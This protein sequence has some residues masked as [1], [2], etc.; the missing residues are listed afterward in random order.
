MN[1][2]TEFVGL[3][4]NIVTKINEIKPINPNL[5]K[6]K[7]MDLFDLMM[8]IAESANMGWYFKQLQDECKSHREKVKIQN[9]SKG[10]M[11]D[12]L[13][14]NIPKSGELLIVNARTGKDR[15][16]FYTWAEENGFRCC[17]AKITMFKPTYIYECCECGVSHYDEE[18][19]YENDWSTINP[20]VCYGVFIRCPNGCDTLFDPSEED[21][22]YN[23]IKKREAFNA[24]IIGKTLPLIPKKDTKKKK[25]IGHGKIDTELIHTIPKRDLQIIKFTEFSDYTI[26]HENYNR[27]RDNNHVYKK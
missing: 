6:K 27:Q 11:L 9:S 17:P 8:P 23:D 20:G 14:N 3:L 13:N 7:D 10:Y 21:E 2:D 24:V 16:A 18:M 1:Q 5:L 25:Y 22:E 12:L 15:R 4:S 26:K 19:R